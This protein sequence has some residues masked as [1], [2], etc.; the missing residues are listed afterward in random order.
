MKRYRGTETFLVPEL[1]ED[2]NKTGK[3]RTVNIGDVYEQSG[4]TYFNEE[5]HL[6]GKDGWIEISYRMLDGCFEEI[7]DE[8]E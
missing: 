6:D 8:G 4:E 1:D 2:W 3:Y 5:I 7:K